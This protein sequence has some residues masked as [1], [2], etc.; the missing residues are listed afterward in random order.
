MIIP[1]EVIAEHINTGKD[2]RERQKLFFALLREKGWKKDNYEGDYMMG[3]ARLHGVCLES[4]RGIEQ[5]IGWIKAM[6]ETCVVKS[7]TA[8]GEFS[9]SIPGAKLY[10]I[11]L[12]RPESP[13]YQLIW[14]I[15]I[16]GEDTDANP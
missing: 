16:D 12:I 15:P 4:L 7:I 10:D 5:L 3:Y 9:P 1:D 13:A 2:W 8:T 14:A 11:E 6:G